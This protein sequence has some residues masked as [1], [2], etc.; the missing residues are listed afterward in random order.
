MADFVQAWAYAEEA[1]AEP[2]EIAR[3]RDLASEFGIK[4]ISPA[5]GNFLRLFIGAA[6]V[7]SA[8]EIGTGTGVSGLYLIG[9]GDLTLTT[10]DLDAEAQ[11]YARD[12]FKAAG[13]RAGKVRLINGASADI[14]PRLAT[15]SYD[16]VLL[17]GNPL[18]AEGDAAE[19]LRLLRPGGTLVVAHALLGGKVADPARREDDV[20]STRNLIK[21]LAQTEGIET[22]LLPVGDGLF[23]ARVGGR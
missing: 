5:S 13:A 4:T 17:D 16:F 2:E 21:R 20:V 19:S 10:I 9:D 22:S 11:H 8:V 1:V 23:I 6:G 15:G 14:L 18:E 3:A 12:F 7:R